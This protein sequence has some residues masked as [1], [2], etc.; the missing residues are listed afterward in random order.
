MYPLY[1]FKPLTIIRV[2]GLVDELGRAVAARLIRTEGFV[3]AL[4]C[5][6]PY[7]R[8]VVVAEK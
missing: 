5:P 7:H 8:H 1:C 6:P 3:A 4:V 2:F